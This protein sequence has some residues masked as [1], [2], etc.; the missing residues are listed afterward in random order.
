[1]VFILY[2]NILATHYRA[3][4]ICAAEMGLL[5]TPSF[6]TRH[7]DWK[8]LWAPRNDFD[9]DASPFKRI[10]WL[11]DTE[12]G[13]TLYE[14]RAIVKYLAMNTGSSLLPNMNDPVEMARFEVACSI[15]LGDFSV[16]TK[17]L[18]YELVQAP[19]VHQ[20]PTNQILVE[21]YK[22][23]LEKTFKGYEKILSRQPYLA[24]DKL[25]VVDLFHIPNAHWLWTV[26]DLPELGDGTLL[27]PNQ[28]KVNSDGTL[29]IPEEQRDGTLPFPKEEADGNLPV[30]QGVYLPHLQ[31][32][33]ARLIQRESVK[34]INAEF[35]KG[36]KEAEEARKNKPPTQ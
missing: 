32:W 27:L 8:N 28:E 23:T 4:L 6:E 9:Y 35:D 30:P 17:P 16:F 22:R 12:A 24:G 1:M 31:A 20:Q 11:E 29:P 14:S 36:L 25:T 15:E 13:I 26:G 3:V 34:K 21:S 33:W 5:D 18:L 10:P 7:V 19:H 2:G